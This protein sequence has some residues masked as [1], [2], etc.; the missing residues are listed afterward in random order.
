MTLE[1]AHELIDAAENERDRLFLRVLWETGVRVSEAIAI[2]L[3]EV[4]RNGIRLL[5]KGSVERVVYIQDGL[6]SAILFCAQERGMARN[7]C[8]FPSR[9]GSHFTKQRADQNIRGGAQIKI[10]FAPRKENVSEPGCAVNAIHDGRRNG[11]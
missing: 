10:I 6:S 11:R 5:G 9:K 8:L 1:E 7:D 2:K 4:G 3:G